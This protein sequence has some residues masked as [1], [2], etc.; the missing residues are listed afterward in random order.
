MLT[1]YD[2]G[3]SPYAQ[4]VKIALRE[5]GI[6][7][8]RR[9]GLTGEG[10]DE[11]RRLSRRAE[12]PLLVDGETIVADSTIILDYLDEKWTD[13]PILPRRASSARSDP[14]AGENLR[15]RA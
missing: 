5:K 12:V 3:L 2:F 1:L 11:L 13:R 6:S 7:F 10:A 14:D 8:D 4:K 9:N 15:Y